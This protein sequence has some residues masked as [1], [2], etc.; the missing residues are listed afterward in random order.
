[1]ATFHTH[2]TA[3]LVTND[4]VTLNHPN[5]YERFCVFADGQKKHRTA[6]FFLA[7]VI[8]G[9]FFLPLPALLSFYYDAPS[10]ILFITMAC[11][12]TN[13]IAFMGGAGIR[14]VILLSIFSI[15]IQLLTALIVII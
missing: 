11:F 2:T 8:Q 6:L 10:A 5:L 4:H 14:T 3:N 7:M 1:M 9:I 15:A 13:I 12:F